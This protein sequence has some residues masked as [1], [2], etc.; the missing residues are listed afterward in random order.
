MELA[1]ALLGDGFICAVL[2]S[3]A[4]ALNTLT[5]CR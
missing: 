5:V 4:G 2:P 3:T 1:A